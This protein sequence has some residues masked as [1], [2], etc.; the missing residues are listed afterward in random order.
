MSAKSKIIT[1][2]LSSCFCISSFSQTSCI[3]FGS[4]N[5]EGDT[6]NLSIGESITFTSGN[7]VSFKT[8][9][10]SAALK[11]SFLEPI[12]G[13]NGG[14]APYDKMFFY[15][16]N[17]Q[18]FMTNEHPEFSQFTNASLKAECLQRGSLPEPDIYVPIDGSNIAI[19]QKNH[20]D[21]KSDHDM[22]I[23]KRAFLWDN[24]E[25][26]RGAASGTC[27]DAH[28]PSASLTI[29][30]FTPE[31]LNQSFERLNNQYYD[32]GFALTISASNDSILQLIACDSLCFPG[33]ICLSTLFTKNT[34]NK[35]AKTAKL[36]GP[37]Y[38]MET[39]NCSVLGFDTG[40]PPEA[41][42]E[43]ID[44]PWGAVYSNIAILD[45]DS[46]Q[47]DSVIL[48]LAE[49]DDYYDYWVIDF[50][51]YRDFMGGGLIT[52]DMEGEI[53][54]KIGAYGWIIVQNYHK[55]KP[56]TFPTE[57]VEVVNHYWYPTW[58]GNYPEAVCGPLNT[59]E[60]EE[61]IS[62]YCYSENINYRL[63][64]P[65]LIKMIGIFPGDSILIPDSMVIVTNNNY[66]F[67]T[68]SYYTY[69]VNS[70]NPL[71][72]FIA[73]DT[74]VSF[75]EK[76]YRTIGSQYAPYN[77]ISQVETFVPEKEK[78]GVYRGIIPPNNTMSKPM[79]Y[80]P[81]DPNLKHHRET[82]L[83]TSSLP[84]DFPCPGCKPKSD[85]RHNDMIAFGEPERNLSE[86]IA[87]P[88]PTTSQVQWPPEYGKTVTVLNANG[89]TLLSRTETNQ[90]DLSTLHQGIYLLRIQDDKGGIKYAKV[91]K[92]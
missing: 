14:N 24:F 89:Q 19:E 51:T 77:L 57:N 3:V 25:Q 32:C 59:L 61:S 30:F 40:N 36:Y 13:D 65:Y 80:V 54:I 74:I 91:M 42:N 26:I 29:K 48:G 10:P 64:F 73:G 70:F 52:K 38:F 39:P 4:N 37:S 49:G 60:V 69:I 6:Y 11:V 45:W 34:D 88:N 12:W 87:S 47:G 1:L 17:D 81:L 71:L 92:Q 22:L 78:V 28:G 43:W 79:T 66:L 9:N 44:G 86:I 2:L 63:K 8:P 33:E 82:L 27:P 31:I 15:A 75:P 83:D 72:S 7:G 18:P 5:Y 85:S 21:P 56:A 50:G 67:D 58:E 46:I 62:E 68:I 55:N 76:K 23:L 53:L 84:L 41:F 90:I 16:E 20:L 35:P